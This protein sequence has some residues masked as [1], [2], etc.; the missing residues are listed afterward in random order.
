MSKIIEDYIGS[1]KAADNQMKQIIN[2][3]READPDY[4]IELPYTFILDKNYRFIYVNIAY[5][6]FYEMEPNSFLGKTSIQLG[7]STEQFIQIQT[8]L[9]TVF[10]KGKAH[11]F[12]THIDVS[13]RG[14]R[15]LEYIVNPL[16]ND[17]NDIE[18]VIFTSADITERLAIEEEL[19]KQKHLYETL[20]EN[21]P[22]IIA[23]HDKD[24][25][26]LFVNSALERITGIAPS[27]FIGK[28]FSNIG[29]P[30]EIWQLWTNRCEDVFETGEIVTFDTEFSSPQGIIQLETILIPECDTKGTIETILAICR[31]GPRQ[32]KHTMAKLEQANE[33]LRQQKQSF[34]TIVEN[35]PMIISRFDKDLRHLYVSPAS[36]ALCGV[37]AEQ[38]LKKNWN[39][40]GIDE[41]AYLPFQRFYEE[42]FR[43]G[44]NIE[45]ETQYPNAQGE[46]A[47]FQTLVIPEM[48]EFGHVQT[49]LSIAQDITAKKK[50]EKEM[51][52]LDRLNLVGE[53]AASIGHEIR[54]PLTTVR[55]YLQLFQ[56]KEE[57]IEYYEQ[58]QTMIDEL[59]RANLIITEFLSL[60]QNKAI[61][62]KLCNLNT[63]ISTLFLL[64]Q[65]DAFR[66]GHT[67]QIEMG[68]VPDINLD[69]KQLR[70][71][72]LNLTRNAFEAM[73]TGGTLT[74]QTYVDGDNAVLA[75]RDTGGGIP[76][77]ILEKI[78]IPFL[79]TKED[80]VG[81]GLAVCYRIA[82]HHSA[83]IDVK[84]SSQGTTFLIA[85]QI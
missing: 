71:L 56:K 2:L 27:D 26:Y 20:V 43:T 30:K 35:I 42:V 45:F 48:D 74:I 1:L 61:E 36:E 38:C 47:Y 6:R 8:N 54:N 52:R 83:K 55:G 63:I 58:F 31:L 10:A 39:E 15:A 4:H 33:E 77:R 13:N 57:T 64:I 34:A 14:K 11:K 17:Q 51:S 5:S 9:D 49:L 84:T 69:E 81:L 25:R 7:F 50:S 70:Q 12:I 76:P 65:A 24:H 79:T 59:D 60:A 75:V 44:Q 37:S 32:L 80:G 72:L 41:T 82:H 67:V 3:R 73:N 23:R 29:F 62:F 53:M 46:M 28:T 78:G 22:D 19:R 85:F 21:S 68:N 16:Y 40:M 66:Y 18:A